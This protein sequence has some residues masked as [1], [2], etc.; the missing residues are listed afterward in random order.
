M[1]VGNECASLESDRLEVH[2]IVL[3]SLFFDRLAEAS[4]VVS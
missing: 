2:L 4:E 3:I 1:I